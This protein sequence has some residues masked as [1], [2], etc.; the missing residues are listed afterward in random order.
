MSKTLTSSMRMSL[1]DLIMR[2]KAYRNEIHLAHYKNAL[3][4]F[5][6]LGY[7][8]ELYQKNYEELSSQIENEQVRMHGETAYQER[9]VQ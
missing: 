8:V 6:Q 5:T 9:S 1:E 3:D 2:T 7:D 4:V